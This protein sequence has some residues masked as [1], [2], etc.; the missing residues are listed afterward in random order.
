MSCRETTPWFGTPDQL[1][2]LLGSVAKQVRDAPEGAWKPE[3]LD[4]AT[5]LVGVLC[6]GL[7]QHGDGDL[8]VIVTLAKLLTAIA[9]EVEG[10]DLVE[11]PALAEALTAL[12]ELVHPLP[13]AVAW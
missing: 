2:S 8:T 9:S 10:R 11:H 4:T 13:W 5:A 6:E 3:V 7:R 12:D 1:S